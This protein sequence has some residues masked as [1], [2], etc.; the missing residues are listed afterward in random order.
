[1]LKLFTLMI[2]D[3]ESMSIDFK[4]NL[5]TY[6]YGNSTIPLSAMGINDFDAVLDLNYTVT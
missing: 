2:L 5:L 6:D 4:K 1:M 3:N